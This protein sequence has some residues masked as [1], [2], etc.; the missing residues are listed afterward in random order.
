MEQGL[1]DDARLAREVVAAGQRAGRGRSRIYTDLR[2]RGIE[3]EQAEEILLECFDPEMER[4]A[5]VKFV[6]KQLD[7]CPHTPTE[8]DMKRFARKAS[9]K[10]FLSSSIVKALKEAEQEVATYSERGFLDTDNQLS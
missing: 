10:G 1:L 8:T 5:A 7:N 3:R 9:A 2:K 6:L 4:Q